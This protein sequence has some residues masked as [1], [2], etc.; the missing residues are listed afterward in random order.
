MDSKEID[1]HE[2][3]YK[4]GKKIIIIHYMDGSTKPIVKDPLYR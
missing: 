3:T 2:T 1:Y 4:D